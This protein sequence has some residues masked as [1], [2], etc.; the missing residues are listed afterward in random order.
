MPQEELAPRV[1]EPSFSNFVPE[2]EQEPPRRLRRGKIKAA[3]TPEGEGEV[4][5]R[6]AQH[7]QMSATH[8]AQ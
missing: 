8:L 1:D 4:S 6:N 7:V 2:Q 3:F 5:L